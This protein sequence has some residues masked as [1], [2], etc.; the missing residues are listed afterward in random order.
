[1]STVADDEVALKDPG[2]LVMTERI[3]IFTRNGF[4][5][6]LGSPRDELA[7]ARGLTPA[8]YP[9]EGNESIVGATYEQ[10]SSRIRRIGECLCEIHA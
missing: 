2:G 5:V 4:D 7:L 9:I 6:E 1:V 10:S 3:R 8:S